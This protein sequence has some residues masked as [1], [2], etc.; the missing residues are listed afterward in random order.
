MWKRALTA[1]VL[2][3]CFTPKTR[4]DDAPAYCRRIDAL[5]E[6]EG[7]LLWAPK[8]TLQGLRYPSG[9]DNGPTTRDGYQLRVGLSYSLVDLYRATRVGAANEADCAA[10]E[11][12][13]ELETAADAMADMPLRDAYQAQAQFLSGHRGEVEAIVERARSRLTEH[14]ITMTEFNDVLDSAD[15]LERQ[16][17][18]AEGNAARIDAKRHPTAPTAST[19]S[20]ASMTRDLLRL[21]AEQEQSLSTLRSLDAWTLR[22][23]GGVIPVA[24]RG[25]EWF[26]WVEL[27]YSLGGLFRSGA[28]ARFRQARREELRDEPNQIPAKLQRIR[29]DVAAQAEQ[30]ETELRVVTRRLGYLRTAQAE[31]DTADTTIAAHLRDSLALD[32]LSAASERA[33]LE[34]L[35]ASTS[36]WSRQGD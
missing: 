9:F 32:E 10:H 34:T 2:M 19:R 6:S 18:Q 5:A 27:S 21:R 36:T 35:V 30:A 22:V 16:A 8:L 23:N 28:E 25:V 3:C 29:A 11:L 31:L 12:Q 20:T 13:R 4:A 7:A 14:V 33:F 15:Q 17:I 1:L 26:G 24:E